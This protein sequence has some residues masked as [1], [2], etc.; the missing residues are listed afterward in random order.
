PPG[1]VDEMLRVLAGTGLVSR[2]GDR[3]A[4]SDGLGSILAAGPL[5]AALAAQGGAT[6]ALA[7]LLLGR[8]AQE[9]DGLDERLHRPDARLL[10]AGAEPATLAVELRRRLPLAHV[11]GHAVEEL[12]EPD[13][14]DIAWLP[15]ADLSPA[16]LR[17]GLPAV[18]RSLRPGGWAL[19]PAPRPD[20]LARLLEEAG[21]GLVRV[22]PV[23]LP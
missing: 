5:R 9:L 20:E 15:A 23:P 10:V 4:V 6:A 13:R 8:L 3:F 19:L 17:T 1:Q 14:F 11:V 7:E 2:R 21:F 22:V 16:A 12:D 18:L